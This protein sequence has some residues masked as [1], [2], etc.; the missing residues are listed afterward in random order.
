VTSLTIG[1]QAVD[2]TTVVARGALLVLTDGSKFPAGY[3]NVVV[4]YTAGY[5]AAPADIE[6]DCIK[7]VAWWFKE[8]DRLGL[9]SKSLQ[10]GGEVESYQTQDVPADVK[11]SLNNWRKVVPA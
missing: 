2:L 6:Q 9:A 5:T 11:T 1:G 10:T 3:G 7:I 4:T 8:R